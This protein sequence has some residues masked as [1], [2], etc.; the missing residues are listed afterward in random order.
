MEEFNRIDF[1]WIKVQNF[2]SIKDEIFF[3]FRKHKGMN[4]IFG[5]NRDIKDG[6][7]N[8][9]G[10]S[11][12]FCD[13]VLFALFGK[14]SKRINK[15]NVINRLVKKQ[16]FIAIEFKINTDTYLI[17]SGI[18]P[19]FVKLC[20]N[21]ENITKST[22]NET[23]DFIETEILKSTFS[24]FKNSIILSVNDSSS[25]FEMNAHQKREFIE[26]IFNLTI[27][28][29]M[30]HNVRRDILTVDKEITEEQTKYTRLEKS[31]KEFKEKLTSFNSDKKNIVKSTCTK[32]KTLE[33]NIKTLKTDTSK[34]NKTLNVLNDEIEKYVENKGVSASEITKIS[35]KVSYLEKDFANKK[36][37]LAKYEKIYNLVGD[38]CK[39]IL[40][41]ELDFTKNQ[42][43]IEKIK[44]DIEDA[45]KSK[46][47]MGKSFLKLEKTLNALKNKKEEVLFNIS[48]LEGNKKQKEI[49]NSKLEL[50][51][52]Q[53]IQQQNKVSPFEDLISQYKGEKDDTYKKL[54][55]K[56][57]QRRYLDF[58]EF[59]L[60]PDGV[61]KWIISNL[62]NTLN[63][64]I[65][66]YLEEMG[67]EYTVVFDPDFSCRFLTT[68]GECDYHNFSSGEKMRVN[69][70]ATFAFRDI[71]AGQGTL[72]SS[73]LVCD[74]LMDV[75]VDGICID[76]LF[77]ILKRQSANQTVFLISHRE[78]FSKK[79]SIDNVIEIVKENG[80]TKIVSDPAVDGA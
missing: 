46:V 1:K 36:R 12:I 15:L 4:Y 28:G 78:E 65:T 62:I 59:V 16:C 40:D 53:V 22:I 70:A 34:Y 44:T 57:E 14:T 60:S 37:I 79:D 76:A 63:T 26:R 66:R 67:A 9:V 71:L 32:I 30:F 18:K 64:R 35:S 52:E 29:K 41:D 17:E 69:H 73:I 5:N 6:G 50:L 31:L 24:I 23:R 39:P 33:A 11:A 13:A 21:G 38:C 77:E 75:S 19:T 45:V 61:K 74:E 56:M 42:K 72:S 20:K 2:L 25:I 43:A 55:G 49:Y 58:C 68:T 7:R 80:T 51:K 48:K 10:K 54:S 27:F 3:D 8:G 47:E